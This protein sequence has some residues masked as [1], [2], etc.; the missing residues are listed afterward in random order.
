MDRI[1]FRT[2]LLSLIT[3]TVLALCVHIE[4]VVAKV[5][6][7]QAVSTKEQWVDSVFS[8]LNTRQK[9]GQ[10]MMVAAFSRKDL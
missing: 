3:T 10:L 1:V 4:P 5:K 2:W 9:I 7:K 8:Q 6:Y